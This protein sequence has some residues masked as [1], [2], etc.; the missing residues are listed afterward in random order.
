MRQLSP[1]N[2]LAGYFTE[3]LTVHADAAVAAAREII[4]NYCS[5]TEPAHD[6]TVVISTGIL[7]YTHI[8]YTVHA[9]FLHSS[10]KILCY[11]L[12]IIILE[13]NSQPP[14]FPL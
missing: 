8:H 10:C 6:I 14:Y 3:E 4:S 13:I 2:N 5:N 1:L 12:D 11:L 7:I 9:Y